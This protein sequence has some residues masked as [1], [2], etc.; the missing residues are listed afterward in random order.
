MGKIIIMLSLS[1]ALLVFISEVD[2]KVEAI[3]TLSEVDRKLK[4][5]NKPAVKSIKSEDGDIIDCVD[6]YKQPAFDHPKLRNHKIQMRPSI[7]FATETSS[8]INESYP[9]LSQTW[10][11]SGSCPKG[12]IPIR[13]IRRHELLSA[14]SL[15]HFGRDGPR[16][17]SSFAVN[18]TNNKSSHFVD[19]NSTK[20]LRIP[21]YSAAYLITTEGNYI[22]ARGNINLWNPEVE[23]SD[24]YT[25]GQIWLTSGLVD[26][27][28]SIEAGWMVN[29]MF[30]GTT[31]V[32]LFVRWTRDGYQTT[33]CINL[34][35]AGFVHTNSRIA[36]GATFNYI[37]QQH[38]SQWQI[39][40][41]FDH[42]PS[43]GN[44]W[45]QFSDE[46]IGYWPAE[47]LSYLKEKASIVAWGGEVY[48]EHV[49]PDKPHTAT[50]MGSGQFPSS[51]LFGNACYI[52]SI[53]IVD[54]SIQVKY[55]D[56]VSYIVD[57]PNC[58]NALIDQDDPENPFFYFGGPGLCA[59]CQ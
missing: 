32:R 30:F 44:W 26:N 9:V 6:I 38:G 49:W 46:V 36:L 23:Y 34:A 55:P 24:E 21:N 16:T 53:R 40:L 43:T 52:A 56:P 14:D 15:E 2:V 45:L 28:E 33:G 59:N 57:E 58:Y 4:L 17:S 8:T 37:S 11:K 50:A 25:T 19:I 12:T 47:I 29:P 3:K 10:Q 54:D 27:F 1:M 5:L 41:R 31:N 18:T 51:G 42:D 35:C 7:T 39:N 13:R 22:G 48:R 20:F